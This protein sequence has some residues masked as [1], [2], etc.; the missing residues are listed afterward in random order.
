MGGARSVGGV[1][2]INKRLCDWSMK[3]EGLPDSGWSLLPSCPLEKVSLLELLTS[4]LD[5]QK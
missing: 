5:T 1:R 2:S 3:W 4:V